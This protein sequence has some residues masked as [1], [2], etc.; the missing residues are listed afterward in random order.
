LPNV[1][2]TP[3]YPLVLA[4][5]LLGR[6][7]PRLAVIFL[8]GFFPLLGVWAVRNEALTGHWFVS[9]IAIHNLRLYRAAGVTTV[10]RT[11]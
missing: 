6:I 11:E 4:G 8:A 3:V 1:V 10:R 2:R 7:K 9:T 5:S